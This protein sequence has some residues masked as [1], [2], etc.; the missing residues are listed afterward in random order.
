MGGTGSGWSFT[1]NIIALRSVNLNPRLIHKVHYPKTETEILGLKLALPLMIAP[2]GG[3]AFNLGE[4]MSEA[5]YQEAIAFGAVDAGI[6]AGTPDAVPLEVM[7]IGLAQ[8]KALGPGLTIPFIKPWELDRID[9]EMEMAREAGAQVV[10]C[11]LDSVGLITLRLMGSPAMAK[12]TVELEKIVQKAHRRGLK[13]IVKGVMS[14]KDAKAALSAEVDGLL[15]SNHGG[16]VLDGAPGM[17]Q[18]LPRIAQE[19]KGRI[20]LLADGGIRSGVDILKTL[21]LGAD[22]VMIGRPFALMAIGGG[23]EAVAFLVNT[24]RSQLEQAMVM[25]GCPDVAKAD[26]SLL[27]PEED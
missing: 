17:A 13:L 22:A 7:K 27:W 25:T 14:L 3:I 18:A 19:L 21:A 16:R 2:I 6:V 12:D 26:R 24:L 8:A 1:N 23:R 11:D 4:A 10:A 5:A 15:I 9:Q 20:P